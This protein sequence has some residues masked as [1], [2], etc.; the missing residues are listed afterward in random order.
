MTDVRHV[1]VSAAFHEGT[2]WVAT[3]AE[4]ALRIERGGSA[5]MLEVPIGLP[6]ALIVD[7]QAVWV[8]DVQGQ[9]WRINPDTAAITQTTSVGIGLLGLCAADGAVWATVNAEG[10]VARS[11]PAED[12]S[13]AT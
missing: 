2:L 3:M 9:I 1:P 11:N 4:R 5:V 8:S 7:E 10:A 12:E 13:L 6:L